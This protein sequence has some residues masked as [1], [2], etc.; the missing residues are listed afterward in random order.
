MTPASFRAEGHRAVWDRRI[1]RA[2]ELKQEYRAV[3][4]PLGF[5]EAVLA[6]QRDVSAD[7][8]IVYQPTIPFGEQFDLEFIMAKF[9]GILALTMERGPETLRLEANTV[10]QAGRPRWE[11]LLESALMLGGSQEKPLDTFFTRACLQPIAENLQSQMPIDPHYTKAVCPAC[12]GLPQLAILRPEGEGASRWLQCS[13][14]LR[15]WLY[16]RIICPFCSEEDR[17]KLPRYQPEEYPLGSIDACDTCKRYLKAVNMTVDG[18]AVPLVDE[19]ALAV[20]DVWAVE[21]GYTK[22]IP[23]LIG[24]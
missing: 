15:E 4:V 2:S 11:N 23:N 1:Q 5:Y 7:A 13:F 21:R 16:R 19:A 20:L 12:G 17:E 18:R 22:I 9:P 10:D 3:S 14:C 24:F 6:F 8:S